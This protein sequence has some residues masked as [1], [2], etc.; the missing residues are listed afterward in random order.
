MERYPSGGSVSSQ[1]NRQ[2]PEGA[3]EALWDHSPSNGATEA[4]R[5]VG[6]LRGPR[7]QGRWDFRLPPP[8][9]PAGAKPLHPHGGAHPAL[10]GPMSP[11]VLDTQVPPAPLITQGGT[12]ATGGKPSWVRRGVRPCSLPPNTS[13]GQGPRSWCPLLQSLRLFPNTRCSG[14]PASCPDRTSCS[15][16]QLRCST[17][18]CEGLGAAFTFVPKW[19]AVGRGVGGAGNPV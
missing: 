5:Q 11:R 8:R 10:R 17:P 16:S 3:R 15:P 14:E 7:L 19:E 12:W 2:V 13:R 1:Q 4:E 9:P 18:L 6:R